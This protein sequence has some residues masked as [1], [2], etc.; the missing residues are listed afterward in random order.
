MY[1]K[2]GIL[3][4]YKRCY[5]SKTSYKPIQTIKRSVEISRANN[6]ESQ[7]NWVW[8]NKPDM[9]QKEI[10]A[11]EILISIKKKNSE[12]YVKLLKKEREIYLDDLQRQLDELFIKF[13]WQEK[14]QDLDLNERIKE[15][16]KIIVTLSSTEAE[17]YK[18][19]LK[20]YK[21]WLIYGL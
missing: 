17:P 13:E 19:L 4:F 12:P 2:G 21:K 10:E 5:A 7:F 16:E 8:I 15:F 6:I 11:L 14:H 20:T 9:I 18:N 1:S 3:L